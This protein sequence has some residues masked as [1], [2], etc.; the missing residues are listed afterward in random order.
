[1]DCAIIRLYKLITNYINSRSIVHICYASFDKNRQRPKN[2]VSPPKIERED[3]SSNAVS[4]FAGVPAFVVVPVFFGMP[5]F[6]NHPIIISAQ[7][8]FFVK[9]LRLCIALI[10]VSKPPVDSPD[11]TPY[12]K[13]PP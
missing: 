3:G 9:L 10:V 7:V 12:D 8:R 6:S 4:A 2:A 1:M 11:N 5:L 13:S